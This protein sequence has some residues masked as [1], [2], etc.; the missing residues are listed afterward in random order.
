MPELG[1]AELGGP[2]DN[3]SERATQ[4]ESQ[5]VR[6]RHFGSTRPIENVRE[7]PSGTMRSW[8]CSAAVVAPPQGRLGSRGIQPRR[9][10]VSMIV[11][12][13][14]FRHGEESVSF[15][16]DVLSFEEVTK[17]LADDGSVCT[18]N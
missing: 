17:Q 14:T 9:P 10:A 4:I 3:G 5:T 13:L 11:P 12:Y 8:G 6:D 15:L 2:P 18:A 1:L 7:G 16:V